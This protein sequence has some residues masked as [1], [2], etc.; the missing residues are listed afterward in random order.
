MALKPNKLGALG[1]TQVL[2]LG[3]VLYAVN[4]S[5]C[6][7]SQT[8]G[9][10]TYQAEDS[11]GVS[12]S[13]S[14]RPAC[15]ATSRPKTCYSNGIECNFIIQTE[16]LCCYDGNGSFDSEKPNVTGICIGCSLQASTYKESS[17]P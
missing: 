12:N 8:K 15:L 3:I 10:E 17:K 4:L 16:Y 9:D 6:C 7:M 2:L 11:T 1:K 5:A 14:E 13:I